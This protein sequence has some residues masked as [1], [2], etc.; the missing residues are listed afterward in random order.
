VN[1]KGA[2]KRP[3]PPAL[4]RASHLLVQP[5]GGGGET[6]GRAGVGALTPQSALLFP[7]PHTLCDLLF[8][9]TRLLAFIRVI[10]KAMSFDL[11]QK[12]QTPVSENVTGIR[13]VFEV[14]SWC[15]RLTAKGLQ[16]GSPGQGLGASC[17]VEVAPV[18]A[19][20]PGLHMVAT[21]VTI[22]D[23]QRLRS[24]VPMPSQGDHTSGTS[25]P[26]LLMGRAE[27]RTGAVTRK[28]QLVPPPSPEV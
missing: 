8:D 16:P 20:G 12:K 28:T 6:S 14:P 17:G 4:H 21:C 15:A 27:G 26:A 5:E 3:L 2:S 24:G 25:V 13:G 7:K 18:Q 23:S 9:F 19:G 10:Y 1:G 22:T 11:Q